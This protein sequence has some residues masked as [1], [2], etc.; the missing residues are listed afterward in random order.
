[1]K[2]IIFACFLAATIFSFSSCGTFISSQ[3]QN[4]NPTSVELRKK[5]IRV[6][7]TSNGEVKSSYVFGSGGLSK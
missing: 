7:G 6:I 2:K 4:P 5:N 1:M 3:K